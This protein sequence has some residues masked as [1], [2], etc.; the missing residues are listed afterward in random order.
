MNV[1]VICREHRTGEVCVCVCVHVDTL[2]IKMCI[3]VI[4]NIYIYFFTCILCKNH[5]FYIGRYP[6]FQEKKSQN[7]KVSK[8]GLF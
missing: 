3:S 5:K 2:Y 7:F 6:I 4:S 8:L 1:N